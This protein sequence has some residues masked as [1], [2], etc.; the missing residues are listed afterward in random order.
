MQTMQTEASRSRLAFL[1]VL[2]MAQFLPVKVRSRVTY[3]LCSG[4]QAETGNGGVEEA[5]SKVMS[6]RTET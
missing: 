3:R 4:A 1:C 2:G 5:H 6:L